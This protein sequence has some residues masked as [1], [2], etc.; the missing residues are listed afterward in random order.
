M[1]PILLSL[2]CLG[3]LDAPFAASSP[4]A[5]G[6]DAD[7]SSVLRA[8]ARAEA[9][10]ARHRE[11]A[12]A[13]R[14][15]LARSLRL[16]AEDEACVAFDPGAGTCPVTVTDFNQAVAA[17]EVLPPREEARPPSFEGASSKEG[18]DSLR[19]AI[20]RR[21][22]DDAYL[23]SG[24]LP[25][26]DRDS[27]DAAYMEASRVRARA[28]R[29]RLGD[30]VL[31]A[32]YREHFDRFFK[33]KRAVRV[34]IL[35]ASDSA[36][37]ISALATSP[38]TAWRWIDVDELPAPARTTALALKPG[39]SAGPLRV[40]FG[41]LCL[42][43]GDQRNLQDTP[44]DAALPLLIELCLQPAGSGPGRDSERAAAKESGP[45]SD[46]TAEPGFARFQAWLRPAPAF[47]REEG[48]DPMETDTAGL[49][50]I[51]RGE[52]N[53]PADVL[54]MLAAFRPIRPGDLLGPLRSAFGVWYF[55]AL[56][57][58]GNRSALGP[59]A[60]AS[61]SPGPGLIA[62][63]SPTEAAKAKEADLRT[64]LLAEYR[65]RSEDPGRR[66]AWQSGLIIRFI[67][68]LKDKEPYPDPQKPVTQTE[69]ISADKSR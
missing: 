40:P 57:T 53:L 12:I 15:E 61:V 43:Y 44:F 37:L 5:A 18:V 9:E 62:T 1:R 19:G 3:C 55:R 49:R 54:A 64:S 67:P 22:L 46:T 56:N 48:R 29:A 41:F 25:W 8:N 35:A 36:W 16:D 32:A 33:G 38:A 30:S 39:G 11:E 13:A 63:G 4:A 10:W 59:Q 58:P 66:A 52:R 65:Q 20:L 42:R 17:E 31:R 45:G 69:S 7:A 24:P 26:R 27:L 2:L 47:R 6:K 60:K 68:I 21:L 14:R 51:E 34:R 28:F 23:R 50:P